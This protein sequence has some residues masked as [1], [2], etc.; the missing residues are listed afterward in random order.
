MP[1]YLFQLEPISILS[2]EQVFFHRLPKKKT[3]IIY[4]KP[5]EPFFLFAYPFLGSI[6]SR[7][8]A[9][10]RQERVAEIEPNPF[11]SQSLLFSWSRGHYKTSSNMDEDDLAL[12]ARALVCGE[13][14]KSETWK[15]KSQFWDQDRRMHAIIIFSAML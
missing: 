5:T 3:R 2:R 11:F 13:R 12:R 6:T 1:N 4:L 8:S 14:P 10:E 15:S 9:K 7:C